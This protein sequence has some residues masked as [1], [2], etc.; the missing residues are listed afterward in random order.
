MVS[1]VRRDFKI[2][3]H[4]V[5]HQA[6]EV[7]DH[8]IPIDFSET[9]EATLQNLAARRDAER[10]LTA[11]GVLVMFPSG[12]VATTKGPFGRAVDAE[13]KP[14]V[15][16]MLLR[17]GADVL[18]VFFHGQNSRLSQIAANL[19]LTLKLALLFHEA[20]NKMGS[21]ISVSIRD[22][23]PNATLRRFG[24]RQAVMEHLRTAT[25]AGP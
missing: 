19:S 17:T 1:Q 20:I 21:S 23:I 25:V 3:T 10:I 4:R 8:I 16:K 24:S 11:G 2:M 9:R 7:R 22:P 18:P 5:L 6:P 14:F 15:A 13:W 12:A